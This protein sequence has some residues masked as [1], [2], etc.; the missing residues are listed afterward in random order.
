MK[1]F[2]DNRKNFALFNRLNLA[3][4]LLVILWGAY[5]R[6]TGSGA[7]CGDHWPLCNGQVIPQADQMKTIIEFAHRATSGI[8]LI[9]VVI[10]LVWARRLAPKGSWVRRVAFTTVI[11]IVL[12]ALLGAGLVL[13]KLVE[14]DQSA[15]RAIS[16]ALHLVNTLF[17]LSSVC[18]LVWISGK[19]PY[20]EPESQKP[21]LPQSAFF[22]GTVGVFVLLGVSGAIT[23]LGDTLF[24]STDL[25]SGMAE[26]FKSGSHFLVKLRV[27]HPI[28]ALT[29][30]A[31]VFGW[32]QKLETIELKG[33]RALLLS[34][35]IVQFFAG[36]LNWMLMAPNWMQLV[37][38]LIADLVFL[39]LW[40]S[41]LKHE[42]RESRI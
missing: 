40:I 5:V 30:I 10:G 23:A 24:P 2:L 8:S 39:V 29:W 6:A 25:V 34:A 33:I 18:T 27:I 19:D 9:L 22:R 20:F 1:A 31:V 11:A 13:L 16:I 12:E 32:S 15:A 41:G 26:D 36:F 3:Y 14:F 38:L 42:A 17:L 21:L 35:V 37:H 4:T 28:L 7:G